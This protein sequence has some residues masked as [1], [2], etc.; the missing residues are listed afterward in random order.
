MPIKSK[1]PAPYNVTG[2]WIH[3]GGLTWPG[4]KL[5]GT[6]SIDLKSNGFKHLK[7]TLPSLDGWVL[8]EDNGK[9]AATN[10]LAVIAIEH[11]ENL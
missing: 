1:P 5:S 6:K 4:H 7:M 11:N 8:I 2:L 9:L 3:T 10:G